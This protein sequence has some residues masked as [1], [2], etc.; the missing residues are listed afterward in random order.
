MR[1]DIFGNKIN[2]GDKVICHYHGNHIKWGIV[3]KVPNNVYGRII[4][5]GGNIHC[6]MIGDSSNQIYIIKKGKNQE[7]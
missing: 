7:L 5:K 3:D 1:L 6:R 2:V 4:V